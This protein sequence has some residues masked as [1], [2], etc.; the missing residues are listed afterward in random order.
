MEEFQIN[1]ADLKKPEK[2]EYVLYDG[3]YIQYIK[4]NAIFSDRKHYND[5]KQMAGYLA[6]GAGESGEGEEGGITK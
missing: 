3:I 2:K 1:C 4:E 5:G 6:R